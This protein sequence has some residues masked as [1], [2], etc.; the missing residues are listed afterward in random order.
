MRIDI[1][2]YV[3]GI[4]FFI[5]TLT[6]LV[7]T[8]QTAQQV[9]VVSTVVLGLAFFGIG[10][11]QRP[12]S[13]NT[14]VTT[15]APP[16]PPPTAQPVDQPQQND[17]AAAPLV[18]TTTT[19]VEPPTATTEAPIVVTEPTSQPIQPLQPAVSETT[20]QEP[21]PAVVEPI[22]PAEDEL[23]KVKGIGEKRATQL[24]A[25]GINSLQDL[26]NASAKD[27]ASKLNISPKITN[28]WIE[29]A[30]TLGK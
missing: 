6:A 15:S 5:V 24:R 3:I 12:R 29:N 9:W 13:A 28:K 20:M 16:P 8:T 2:S 18:T 22:L 23:T 4:V 7:Y 19:S 26:A 17:V 10:Y 27:L 14:P 11:T 30:K 25:N 1:A 21:M